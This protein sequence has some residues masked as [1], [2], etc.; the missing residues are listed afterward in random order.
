MDKEYE[1][2]KD[3]TF[4]PN[5]NEGIPQAHNQVVVVRGLSRYMELQELRQ[6]KNQDKI[7]REIE[8]FGLGHKFAPEIWQ[9]SFTY[10]PEPEDE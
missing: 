8:L 7:E 6:K 2:L 4:K 1:E 5:I 9:D 3:C 10:I